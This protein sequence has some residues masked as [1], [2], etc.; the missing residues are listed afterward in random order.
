MRFLRRKPKRP[1]VF[2]LEHERE[3]ERRAT[4]NWDGL[5]IF[6]VSRKQVEENRLVPGSFFY[7]WPTKH[8][9]VGKVK[10]IRPHRGSEEQFVDLIV[11]YPWRCER[12]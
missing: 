10:A 12:I 1:S 11:E 7:P 9:M 2:Q 5:E 4:Q 3:L 6:T 8:P